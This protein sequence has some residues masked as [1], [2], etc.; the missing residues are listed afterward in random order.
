MK[1]YRDRINWKL[2]L[3]ELL[4]VILGITIAFYIEEW[5]EHR[6][7]E[8][9]L[10]LS[11]E[12]LIADLESDRNNLSR[13][14]VR[15]NEQKALALAFTMESIKKGEFDYDSLKE[16]TPLI[17]SMSSTSLQTAALEVAQES[18]SLR[19]LQ[20]TVLREQI[21]TYYQANG[22]QM[23]FLTEIEKNIA[24]ELAVYLTHHFP[25][26]YD[27]NYM[28]EELY[29]D[30]VFRNLLVRYQKSMSWK[31]EEYKRIE[32]DTEDLIQ[33]I[34]HELDRIKE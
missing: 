4:V 18:G 14:M 24:N 11:L 7:A 21:F 10:I 19:T 13:Y 8:K 17:Y 3:V 32:E 5:R 31:T 23:E 33:A 1:T 9:S 29:A 26:H 6:K 28:S 20:N 30:M 2:Q 34:Q 16:V 25:V 12:S 22:G 27:G 15:V